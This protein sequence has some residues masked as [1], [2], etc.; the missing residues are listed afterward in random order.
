[1]CVSACQCISKDP[2]ATR[3][4]RGR[5]GCSSHS[6]SDHHGEWAASRPCFRLR[7]G[8]TTRVA[9]CY[10]A[11]RDWP[12]DRLAILGIQWVVHRPCASPDFRGM[13]SH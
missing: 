5:E 3:V 7:F 6:C 4:R 10:G 11:E 8:I 12:V 2:R 13:S 9:A 1:M